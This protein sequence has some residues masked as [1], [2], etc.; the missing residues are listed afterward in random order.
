M[1]H[2]NEFLERR[3]QGLAKN[4]R[5]ALDLLEEYEEILLYAA[6]P[7]RRGQCYRAVEQLRESAENY[8]HEYDGLREQVTGK[9]SVVMLDVEARLAGLHDKLNA[10][11]AGQAVIRDQL[12]DLRHTV[13]DRFDASEQVIINAVVERL[14]END[15]ATVQAVLDGLDDRRVPD[16]E[17]QEILAAVQGL[18]AEIRREGVTLTDPAL[19]SGVERMEEVVKEPT[20]DVSHKLKLSVPIIP[21]ILSYEGELGLASGLNL[22]KAWNRLVAKWKQLVAKV[23]G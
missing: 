23:G 12:A 8:Q 11:I 20:L 13:L 3:L 18:V 10:L 22:D 5:R 9:P 1:S 16:N 17:L 19:A 7:R 6:D 15:L 2:K 4:I 21:F 14:D